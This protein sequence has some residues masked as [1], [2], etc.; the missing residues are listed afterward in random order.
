[1]NG[2]ILA[3][4]LLIISILIIGILFYIWIYEPLSKDYN[5]VTITK[6]PNK[7]N[8]PVFLIFHWSTEDELQVG[9]RIKVHADIQGLPY[10]SENKSLQKIEVKFDQSTLNYNDESNNSFTSILQADS[11]LFEPNWKKNQFYSNEINIRFITPTDVSIE[12]CDYNIQP[13][14]TNVK[15]IIHPAPH[16][17]Y[18]QIQNN[19]INLGVSLVVILLSAITVW[20]TLRPKFQQRVKNEFEPQVQIT[21]SEKLVVQE[22]PNPKP[23]LIPSE[24]Q[25]QP[26]NRFSDDNFYEKL[27]NS[28]PIA[29]LASLC[30]VVAAFTYNNDQLPDVYR[31]AVSAAFSFVFSFALSLASQIFRKYLDDM[32]FDIFI[33]IGIYFLFGV[34]ILYLIFI[35]ISFGSKLPQ[36][37]EIL[38]SWYYAFLGIIAIVAAR[39]TIQKL[40][41]HQNVS[42]EDKMGLPII[43][44][45][46]IINWIAVAMKLSPSLIGIPFDDKIIAPLGLG[47]FSVFGL[48]SF[49]FSTAS[50]VKRK[51]KNFRNPQPSKL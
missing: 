14:C 26:S 22:K 17:L 2:K 11:L 4:I 15:K 9:K 8:K 47:L 42:F 46:A 25:V 37:P 16:D 21:K 3:D 51:T 6:I 30:M 13:A 7:Y 28:Q 39:N 23:E 41:K 32:R 12:F 50:I 45:L 44:A 34:G 40:R 31:N 33:R 18:V 49:G 5:F 29:F 10:S 19:R 24:P 35:G 38:F 20:A 48:L 27:K 1:M 36:I 43:I